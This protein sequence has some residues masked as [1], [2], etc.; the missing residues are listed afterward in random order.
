MAVFSHRLFRETEIDN[1]YMNFFLALASYLSDF[2]LINDICTMYQYQENTLCFQETFLHTLKWYVT[3]VCTT[4][5][6]HYG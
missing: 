2:S 1:S 4:A 3:V 5:M 6:T